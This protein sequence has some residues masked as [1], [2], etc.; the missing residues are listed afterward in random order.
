MN[1][2]IQNSVLYKERALIIKKL[3]KKIFHRPVLVSRDSY[4]GDYYSLRIGFI[5]VIARIYLT[6]DI[7][8]KLYKWRYFKRATLFC[9]EAEKI[10]KIPTNIIIKTA[11]IN[12]EE[13]CSI[14]KDKLKC[15]TGPASNNCT[16][17]QLKN[18]DN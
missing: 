14:C 16:I 8:L 18:L 13:L 10:L 6:G 9:A 11:K 17:K 1:F 7:E 2:T 12:K 5:S 4:I 15:L 3:T